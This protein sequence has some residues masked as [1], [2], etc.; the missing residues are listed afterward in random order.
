[1]LV[2]VTI[3]P[4]LDDAQAEPL[5]AWAFDRVQELGRELLAE[6]G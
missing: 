3:D 6:R 2:G 4:E 1:M 5:A